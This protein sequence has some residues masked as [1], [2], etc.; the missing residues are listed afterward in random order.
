LKGKRVAAYR[1]MVQ[2]LC[3]QW[4]IIMI[5][6]FRT[7]RTGTKLTTYMPTWRRKIED[8]QSEYK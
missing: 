7:G 8:P 2:S 3:F 1:Q 5:N 6:R 4:T